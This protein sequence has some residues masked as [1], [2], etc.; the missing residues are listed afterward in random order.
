MTVGS[1]TRDNRTFSR[2]YYT[3]CFGERY[4]VDCYDGSYYQKSWSGG[5]SLPSQRTG[6]E[7]LT[8]S[9]QTFRKDGSFKGLKTFRVRKRPKRT[10]FRSENPYYM[11]LE[12]RNDRTNYQDFNC[13]DHR[14]NIPFS[15][16][17]YPCYAYDREIW[18]SNDQLSLVGKLTDSLNAGF[19]L[20]VFLGEGK[21][22]LAT[23]TQMA[24]RIYRAAKEVKKGRITNAAN[25]LL[26]G[27][28][29]PG[30]KR[31]KNPHLKDLKDFASNWLQLQYGW[32][33]LIKD[34]FSAAKHLAYLQD[35]PFNQTFRV[36]KTVYWAGDAPI[37]STGTDMYSGYKRESHSII[38]KV[39]SVNEAAL[40]GLTDPSAVVWELMPYS[41][42]FDWFIPLGNYL[43]AINLRSA[44]TATYILST[45]KE[46]YVYR[47][48][49]NTPPV[50]PYDFSFTVRSA[51]LNRVVTT[52]L[53]VP[54]PEVKR[55]DQ[56]ASWRHAAN[57]VAL[58][59][60]FV[61][62]NVH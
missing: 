42:V 49:N 22:A 21:E 13:G 62:K 12:V 6:S 5:D 19:N 1:V 32:L 46:G 17:G 24:T 11:S 29:S 38:A 50:Q 16:H 43:E 31:P 39:T 48:Y 3:Y 54:L 20:A 41:F 30:G 51:T 18:S 8:F 47:L 34:I 7:Y 25:I 4:Y 27:G 45:W 56:I 58:V 28:K 23:I 55:L 2:V 52:T 35:R 61:L 26:G 44:L 40:L 59:T 14:I 33:P 9:Y 60:Q 36:R 53:P 57:A 15:T 37:G 10:S